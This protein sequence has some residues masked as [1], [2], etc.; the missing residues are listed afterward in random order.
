[1]LELAREFEASNFIYASSSSVYGGNKQFPFREDHPVDQPISPYAATKRA[2]ETQAANYSMLYGFPVTGFRFFTVYG[3]GGR[4]DMA[5]RK[6]IE[7]MMNGKPVPLFGDG[8]FERDYTY[9]EDILD[10]VMGAVRTANGR[11]GWCEVF[12]LGESETTSV[13]QIILLIAKYLGKLDLPGDARALPEEKASASIKELH[14]QGLVEYLP[15][16]LGDV[17]KTY[18]D[19]SKARERIG[20]NPKTRIDEGIQRTVEW[21]REQA[22]H[23][24]S[25]EGRALNERIRE[26]AALRNRAGLDNFGRPKDPRYTREDLERA[27]CCRDAFELT[28]LAG[29][30]SDRLADRLLA[31]CYV[32]MGDIASYLRSPHNNRPWGVQGL[33]VRRK[34]IRMIQIIRESAIDGL[35]EAEEQR[36]ID[37][38]RDIIG[39]TGTRQMAVVVAAAGYGTRL[40]DS[41][42]GYER[43]HKAFF[44]DDMILL[45]LRTVTPY[46]KRIVIV[47]SR[48]NQKDIEASLLRSEINENHGFSVDYVIQ[49][50][51]FGDGDAHLTAG[52]VLEN[53]D[54]VILFIFSDAPTKSPG[55]VEKM[56]LVKQALGRLAPLVVPTVYEEEPYAPVVLVRN[57]PD[58]GRVIWNWQKAD[59]EDFEEAVIARRTPGLRNVG[60]FAGEASV[61]AALRHYKDGA[62]RQSRRYQRWLEAMRKWRTSG[63][64]ENEAPREPEFGFADLMKVLPRRGIEGVAPRLASEADRLNVNSLEDAEAAKEE[65]RRRVSSCRMDSHLHPE[66]FC[67]DVQF[68]DLD[69]Q[70]QPIT[71]DGTPSYRNYTRIRFAEGTDLEDEKPRARVNEVA[72]AIAA[73]IEADVGIRVVK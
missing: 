6:F 40:A 38:A 46:A 65:I 17:P 53:F 16:Q 4:P 68:V 67:I 23:T 55:T 26:Y 66:D 70:G 13:R 5:I 25:E 9:I 59:E 49:E 50:Q 48:N 11:K 36:L 63:R 73:R 31:G 22:K 12:N 45:S 39:V 18:A 43:K 58:K 8:S 51:R 19:I 35:S 32:L 20:Y 15:Q 29:G 24:E 52:E 41:L 27:R 10:G 2:N 61:F 14:K 7:L 33:D 34:R 3:P 28:A 62:F 37:L 71:F 47:A 60:L 21:H 64:P 69:H 44:G 42:G 72:R 1:M 57:G 30:K 56:V 54:G